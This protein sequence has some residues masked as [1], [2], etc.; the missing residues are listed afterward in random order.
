MLL[1]DEEI[2]TINQTAEFD[3]AIGY[4]KK[5]I[6]AYEKKL[7]EQEPRSYLYKHRFFDGSFLYSYEPTRNGTSA[8]EAI[9]LY[10]HPAPSTAYEKKLLDQAMVECVTGKPIYQVWRSTDSCGEFYSW[11]DCD[12]YDYDETLGDNRRVLFEHPAPIPEEKIAEIKRKERER[13]AALLENG[14]FLHDQAPT[15][16]FATEAAKAIRSLED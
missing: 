2:M 3:S 15:K 14:R 5:I 7:R 10:L 4:A 13:C 8:V 11:D 1:T 12:K 9:P 16:L 6:A